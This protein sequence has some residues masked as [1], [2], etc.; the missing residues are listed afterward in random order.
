MAGSSV[1]AIKGRD[2]DTHAAPPDTVLM[3]RVQGIGSGPHREVGKLRGRQAVTD[4]AL[5]GMG[6]IYAFWVAAIGH[7]DE[8]QHAFISRLSGVR[9]EI[10]DVRPNRCT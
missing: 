10:V 6:L 9:P 8:I 3:P 5:P 4:A 1:L 7:I 2:A